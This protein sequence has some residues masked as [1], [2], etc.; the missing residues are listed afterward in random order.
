MPGWSSDVSLTLL[1]LSPSGQGAAEVIDA[2]QCTAG[3]N[4]VTLCDG[5]PQPKQLVPDGLDAMLVV[6]NYAT[7]MVPVSV[8][9]TRVTRL[10][11]SN[12]R[13]E[14]V[15]PSDTNVLLTGDANTALVSTGG[16]IHAKDSIDW[17]TRCTTS[18]GDP[19]TGL[20]NG[21]VLLQNRLTGLA[22]AV[23][24]S[25]TETGASMLGLDAPVQRRFGLWSGSAGSEFVAR[26]SIPLNESTTSFNVVGD[27]NPLEQNAPRTNV[28]TTREEAA[29]RALDFLDTITRVT[30]SEW[31]GMICQKATGFEWSRFVT[32]FLPDRIQPVDVPPDLCN[33]AQ[34]YAA[35]HHTHP[36]PYESDSF[37]GGDV[38]RANLHTGIPHYLLAPKPTV[39]AGGIP[40]RVQKLK[41]W[42]IG[43]RLAE[44][45]Q[46]VLQ[47]GVWVPYAGVNGSEGARCDTP[48]P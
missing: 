20:L 42:R 39:P 35:F 14:H 12:G 38:T 1:R 22:T 16:T 29:L 13:T 43:D 30:R 46:C 2:R 40:T 9:E 23:D 5:P 34:T 11:G 27:G 45:N 47:A 15:V 17:T 31:G 48:T 44:Y 26:V 6:A 25:C 3:R 7:S 19:V 28:F 41:T 8:Y 36:L 33:V 37:S 18:A 21:G 32:S 24:E 10:D 4:Q